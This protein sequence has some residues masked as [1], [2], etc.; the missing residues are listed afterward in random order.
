VSGPIRTGS[1]RFW[2]IALGYVPAPPPNG[3]AT[4]RD[5]YLGIGVPEDELGDGNA[6]DREALSI[7]P[8][9]E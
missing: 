8:T 1:Y 7:W 9:A 6:V 3:H 2:A 4:R 5:Y